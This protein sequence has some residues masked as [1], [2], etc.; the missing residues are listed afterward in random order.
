MKIDLK[1]VFSESCKKLDIEVL[2][3][4]AASYDTSVIP[5]STSY[6]VIMDLLMWPSKLLTNQLASCLSKYLSLPQCIEISL[7]TKNVEEILIVHTKILLTIAD[8]SL[9]IICH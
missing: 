2:P 6:P 5:G 1:Y 9:I 8:F 4:S 7:S 3:W